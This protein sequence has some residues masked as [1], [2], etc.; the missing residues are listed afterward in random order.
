MLSHLPKLLYHHHYPLS[1]KHV[2]LNKGGG[3]ESTSSS[4]AHPRPADPEVHP[5]TEDYW[6]HVNPIGPEPA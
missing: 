4:T 1:V 5:Q 6:G 3:L 2:S